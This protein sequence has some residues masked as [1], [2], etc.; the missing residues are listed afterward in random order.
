ML[1]IYSSSHLY[2]SIKT[3]IGRFYTRDELEQTFFLRLLN[4]SSIKTGTRCIMRLDELSSLVRL[5]RCTSSRRIM[6]LVAVFILD[7]FN[8]RR[9]NVC[10]SSSQTNYASLV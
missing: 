5:R 10:P 3:A 9:K 4:S 7:E 2:T 8:R 6:R 1:L